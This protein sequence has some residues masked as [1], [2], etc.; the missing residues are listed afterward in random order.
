MSPLAG[1]IAAASAA[2]VTPG[3]D[4]ASPQ[5]RADLVTG[6]TDTQKPI[7]LGNK[8]RA[9][10]SNQARRWTRNIRDS[11]LRFRRSTFDVGL[12]SVSDASSARVLVSTPQAPS[13]RNT[14]TTSNDRHC[15]TW[16]CV[17]SSSGTLTI[18]AGS[19]HLQVPRSKAG[20]RLTGRSGQSRPRSFAPR[21]SWRAGATRA[22]VRRRVRLQKARGSA[23]LVPLPTGDGLGRPLHRRR[24]SRRLVGDKGHLPPV[25]SPKYVEDRGIE[26]LALGLQSRCSPAELIPRVA[27]LVARWR[28][29][30]QGR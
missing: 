21:R 18:S 14:I 12:P 17:S 2:N 23:A 22:I 9:Q 7:A 10:C 26:P 27:T 15:R 16:G 25:R 13:T 5:D 28:L 30:R 4:F 6:Y 19:A 29:A 1:V 8:R 11:W 3:S 24:L 20:Q